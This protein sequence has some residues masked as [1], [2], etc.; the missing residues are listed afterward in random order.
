ML[1]IKIFPTVFKDSEEFSTF[2][3]GIVF[4]WENHGDP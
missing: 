1:L 2:V 4:I 3:V